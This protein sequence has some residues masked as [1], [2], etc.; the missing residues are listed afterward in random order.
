VTQDLLSRHLAWEGCLNVRDLG[1]IRTLDGSETQWRSVI[2]AD[3][4]GRLSH[5]GQRSMCAYGVCTVIDLRSPQEVYT[6]SYQLAE[7]DGCLRL[8]LPIE[9]FYPHVS[10]RIA[11]ATSLAEVY[12]LIADHYADAIA[13]ILQAVATAPPGGVVIH[14]YGGKDRTGTIAA[15]LLSIAGV[16][17]D[18]IAKD[19]AASQVRLWPEYEQQL[20]QGEIETSEDLWRRPW[21]AP[22]TM[23]GF[24]GHLDVQYGGVRAYLAQAGMQADEIAQLYGRLRGYALR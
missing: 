10:A 3:Y 24:L 8:H 15:L 22:E 2:R 11:Q 5:A 13:A 7:A 19:Y 23:H 6:E 1:G 17:A 21:A 4:L 9:K 14:C 20:Q 16:P 18:E 12:C